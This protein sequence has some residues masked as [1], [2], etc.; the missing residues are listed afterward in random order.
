MYR[1]HVSDELMQH[2]VCSIFPFR[3]QSFTKFFI[4]ISKVVGAVWNSISEL[5]TP[6]LHKFRCIGHA[7]GNFDVSKLGT[8]FISVTQ[9][10][11]YVITS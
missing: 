8:D 5:Q 4:Y 1:C 9:S 3:F 6:N 2:C 7:E 10:L 11:D